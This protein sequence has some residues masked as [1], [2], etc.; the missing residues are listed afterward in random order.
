MPAVSAHSGQCR[1]PKGWLGRIILR[2]MNS[3]HSRLTDWGLGFVAIGGQSAVLDV[4]CGGGRTISKLAA[5]APDAKVHGLDHSS[6]SVTVASKLNAAAIQAGRV[7]IREG[8]VSQLPYATGAFDLVT[9]VETHFFWPDLA[10]DVREVVRVLSP[11]GT[12]LLIAEIYAG[13]N[14]TTAKL[15]GKYAP[16]TGMTLLTPDGHRRLLETAGFQDVQVAIDSKRGWICCTG[17]EPAA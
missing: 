9:A 11:G 4:G 12:F 2:N 8:S 5:K 17:K 7:E 1:K 14:T 13:A 6:A 16:I 3:R 10:N 15:C